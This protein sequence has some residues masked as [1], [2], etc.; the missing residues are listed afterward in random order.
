[1]VIGFTPR[2]YCLSPNLAAHTLP[3][4]AERAASCGFKNPFGLNAS[5]REDRHY[6]GSLGDDSHLIR[7]AL[8]MATCSID[9]DSWR[10]SG[11]FAGPSLTLVPKT[12]VDGVLAS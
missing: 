12:V 6:A 5:H 3:P 4:C 7:E 10:A 8:R 1:M 9:A 2:T 11:T